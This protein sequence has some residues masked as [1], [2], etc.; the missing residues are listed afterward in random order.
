MSLCDTFSDTESQEKGSSSKNEDPVNPENATEHAETRDESAIEHVKK[1]YEQGDMIT[2]AGGDEEP[3][4]KK[5]PWDS[6]EEKERT[7]T[8]KRI[9]FEVISEEA[10]NNWEVPDEMAKYA[11]KYFEKYVSDKELKDSITL[12]SPVPTNLPKVKNMDD[13]FVE[14]LEDQRKKNEIDLDDTSKK[15]Q[16]KILTIMGPLSK[17]WY[18]VKESLAG[19]SREFDV[20]EMSQYI[21]QTI[22]L[23]GQAFNSVSYSRRMNVLIGVGTEKVKAKN[24]LKNQASLLEEDSKELFGKSFRKHMVAT[25]KAEKESK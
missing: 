11:K 10:Q 2:I 5:R 14:L 13:Y 7:M 16:S 19:G 20:D 6:E 15:L 8:F 23:I 12:N 1:P 25:A 9:R 24:P 3:P 22:L 18:T 17:V 21:D 4:R